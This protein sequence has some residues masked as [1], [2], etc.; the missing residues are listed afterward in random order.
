MFDHVSLRT[1]QIDALVAFYEA[2]LAPLGATKL[3]AFDGGAAFGRD[4]P[5]LWMGTSDL[6]PSSVHIAITSR[7]RDAVDAFHAAAVAAGGRDNG[8]PGPRPDYHATYYGAFV[9]DPDGNN[10]EAVCHQ[11]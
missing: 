11:A 8:K 3:V 10:I 9:I 4:S 7:T 2:A 6:P 5:V 1:G